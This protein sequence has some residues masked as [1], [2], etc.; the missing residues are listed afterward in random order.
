M[1]SDFKNF[2]RNVRKNTTTLATAM[3][4]NKNEKSGTKRL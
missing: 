2:T 3:L 4:I 1:N